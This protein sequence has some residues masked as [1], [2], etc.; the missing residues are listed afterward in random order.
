MSGW[1]VLQCKARAIA[2]AIAT[3][4]ATSAKATLENIIFEEEKNI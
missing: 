4:K 2:M 3:A 1:Y